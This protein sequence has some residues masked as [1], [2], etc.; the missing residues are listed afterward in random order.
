MYE[1]EYETLRQELNENKKYVFERPLIIITAAFVAL[2][3]IPSEYLIFYPIVIIYLLL[4][5]LS[6]TIN[7][8]NSSARIVAYIRL[9]IEKN[10]SDNYH[11][12]TF[13][14]GYQNGTSSKRLRFYPLIF[15]FHLLTVI[16]LLIFELLVILNVEKIPTINY[17]LSII[18]GLAEL[19]WLVKIWFESSSK[20]V[21]RYFMDETKRTENALD[22]TSK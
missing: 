1:K 3:S 20:K 18:I 14:G 7:R 9:H 11:W 2:G 15:S 19:I 12:E 16:A 4:F 6:F 22:Q 13:L 5:N 21:T 17:Y 8:L 10:A